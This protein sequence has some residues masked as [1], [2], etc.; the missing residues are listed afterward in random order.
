MMQRFAR[1]A[2]VGFRNFNKGSAILKEALEN[3]IQDF[4]NE[5]V[6]KSERIITS[7]QAAEINVAG[8]D[9]PVLNFCANNYLGLSD[10]ADL[11]TAAKNTLDTHGFGLSSVRFICGTQD[12][13]KELEG[14]IAEFHGME[15]TILYASC[16]DANG[17]V[18]EGVL[19][20]EDCVISDALNHA[21]IIDGIRLCKAKRARYDHMDMQHLESLLKENMDKRI[22][23]IVTDGVFSMDGDVAPMKEIC[24]LADKYDAIV[25]MDESHS[26]GFFGATGRGTDEHCG[27]QGRVDIINST[28]GKALGGATGGYTTASKEVV[29]ILRQKSRPYLFSNSLCPPVVGASI[30][31]FDRLME[32]SELVEK[33]HENTL[34]FRDR[35]EEAGFK[36]L[37]CRDHPIA[38][39]YLGDARLAAE[40]ADAMLKKGIYV[41]GFSFPVVPRGEAR[42]RVQIS[43]AHSLDQVD[44]A[45]DAF[46]EVGKEKGVI[47]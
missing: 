13:H 22:R 46:I 19:T 7:M 28:M 38:P 3:S 24:D 18:F 36:I 25:F 8:T 4:K 41:I 43:A 17:G 16:F 34:R 47:A 40:F 29:D 26:T 32:S 12:I 45:V 37:G 10:N 14:K 27:V 11:I 35:M 42:I 20:P 5:G 33:V 2:V 9:E 21:S 30:A 1:S 31:V 15:D 39:V 23:M 44:R 6:Y